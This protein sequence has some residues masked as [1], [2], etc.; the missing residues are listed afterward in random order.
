MFIA[1]SIWWLSRDSRVQDFD[2]GLHTL[3][4]FA[5]HDYIS[6]GQLTLPFTI[7]NTYPPLVHL[8]GA[9]GV[10]IGGKSPTA[11]I[12]ASN[13]VFVP[14]LAVSCY[15][16]GRLVY[17]P[18][19]GLLA[20]VFALGTPM[21]VSE[22][23]AF[24]LD[25]PQAAMV[26]ASVWAILATNR[27]EHTGLAVVAGATTGL[28]MLTKE[29]AVL[30]VAGLAAVVVL[31]G[32][33]RRWRGMLAFMLALATV[34]GPWY[35]YHANDLHGLVSLHE[36][37]GA[38]AGGAYPKLGSIRSFAWYFWNAL[39]PQLLAPLT[40]A[41]V[42]GVVLAVRGSLRRLRPDNLL[43]E[44]LAG[45]FV[46]WLGMTLI[47]HKDPRY[48]LPA[49][50]YFAVLGTGWIATA[51]PT[52]R[53]WLITALAT[54][55]AVNFAAVSFGIGHP[56]TAT[57]S[58]HPVALYSPAGYV[59]GGP[60]HDGDIP[61]LMRGL[62]RAGVRSLTFDAGSSNSLDFN[63]S[64][65]QVRAI[66]AGVPVNYAY[67]LSALGPRDAF[68]LRHVPQPGDPP[69][70]RRLDDGT[71]VYVE[72]GDPLKPFAKYTFICPGRSPEFYRRTAPLPV[73][74]T[75]I[76]GA[77]RRMLLRIMRAMRRQGIK[78]VE[79]DPASANVAFFERIGLQKLAKLARL[80]TPPVYNPQALGIHDA[81]MLRHP[82]GADDPP[83]CGRFPDGTGLYIVLG[84]PVIPFSDYRFYCPL[85][86]PRFYRAA[87]R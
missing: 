68:M 13:F 18:R 54:V 22:M 66:E 24:I 84:N 46:A 48:T 70:C 56:V 38:G 55:V 14:L 52:F 6:S 85:R 74:T 4:A 5:D 69:P 3:Y 2:N 7:F 11:V 8:V 62:R 35:A 51:T 58:G 57:V 60:G 1:V 40:L 77:P 36:G 63:I 25:P 64:G 65:L 33:W 37:S 44:L 87:G 30:F 23:H 39:D 78:V 28:A 86:R 9:L 26:A 34:A 82:A 76:T 71:G 73:I 79:F 43:P 15:G 59:R 20:A 27:F 17:G 45:G 81:F 50:I 47:R 32:G 29:T 42:I 19:A 53:R 67:N 72:L 49:L 41:F 80:G 16:V 12:L 21:F 10:F 83:P 75:D 61:S 31:R